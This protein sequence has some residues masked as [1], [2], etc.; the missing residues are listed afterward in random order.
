MP[1][2]P[3]LVAVPEDPVK[4]VVDGLTFAEWQEVDID[5]D[6]FTAADGFSLTGTVP[7]GANLSKFREGARVDVYVGPDRQMA[8]VID[9]VD[10][11][12]SP[13]SLRISIS[14]RDLGAYITDS[15]TDA[16]RFSNYTLESLAKKLLK[17]EWGI[18]NVVVSNDDNRKVQ[19]GKHEKERFKKGKPQP[20]RI[21][22]RSVRPHTKVDVGQSVRQVLDQ[23]C[24]RAGCAWWITAQGDLFIG[25][26]Q[27]EQDP[28]FSFQLYGLNST[29]R[30]KNN[31]LGARVKR[32]M[33]ERYSELV[34]VGESSQDKSG[35]PN[36]FDPDDDLSATPTAPK[37][38][39]KYRGVATDPDLVARGIKRRLVL[40]DTDALS[41]EMCKERADEEMGRRRLSALVLTLTVDG[42]RQGN[43]LFTT[44][45][46]AN[47]KI[48]EAGVDGVY[49]I[50]QRKFSEKRQERRTTLTLHEKGVWLA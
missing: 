47:V 40:H 27:Y 15:E 7:S 12:V 37:R 1:F 13:Q 23:H 5:S 30:G 9:E 42:F 25:R 18:K 10:I 6:V 35:K 41:N 43:R 44:D 32:S 22:A 16:L 24:G 28:V 11:D 48:D 34:I 50:S 19:L 14:G 26:P 4:V 45:C 20:S 36:I 2:K 8:G 46:L 49:W 39:K 33:G 38:A 31:V 29:S 17:P 3:Q 21:G